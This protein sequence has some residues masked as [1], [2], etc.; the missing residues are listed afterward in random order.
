MVTGSSAVSPLQVTW[1]RQNG[2]SSAGE[3][4]VRLNMMGSAGEFLPLRVI[5]CTGGSSLR[6]EA[7]AWW[8]ALNTRMGSSK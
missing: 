8:D 1:L 3:V 5:S 7:G 6:W 4:K 2:F